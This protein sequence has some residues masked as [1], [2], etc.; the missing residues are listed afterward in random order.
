MAKRMGMSVAVLRNKLAPGIKTHHVNDEE[1]SLII[2][3]SQ[4]ANVEEPC[5]ALIAKNYRHG[6]IAFPMPA[7]QH[8]SDDDLTHALCRAMKECSDVTASASSALADGRVTAAELDQLEKE[9][10]EA[11]AAIVELRERYRA[12]AEGSK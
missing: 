6:L 4:E 8:L 3:F 9:T 10:Q 1:D 7:V 2:E 12:R 5:R 11:L